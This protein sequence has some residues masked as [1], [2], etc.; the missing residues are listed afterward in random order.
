MN[1]T[2]NHQAEGDALGRRVDKMLASGRITAAEAERVRSA[3]TPAAADAAIQAIRLRHMTAHVE[4]AVSAGTV[5][6]SDGADLLEQAKHEGPA[7]LRSIRRQPREDRT[8]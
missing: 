6:E 1:E 3:A 2:P 8:D 5:G 7:A 4:D